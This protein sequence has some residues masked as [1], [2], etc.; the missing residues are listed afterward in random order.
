MKKKLLVISAHPDDEILGCG[1]S[2]A[3]FFR[4]GYEIRTLILSKGIDSRKNTKNKEIK[5]ID[6]IKAAVKANRIVGSKK[7]VFGD[8]PDNKFDTVPLLKIAQTIERHINSFKPQIIFTHHFNDLNIDHEIVNRASIIATRPIPKKNKFKILTYEV[9]SSTDWANNNKYHSFRANYFI[10]ISKKDLAKKLEALRCYKLEMR[11]WPH[12]RS[13]QAIKARSKLR[14]SS[15]G[16][17]NAEAFQLYRQ[18]D[19]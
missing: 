1:A 11:N 10:N 15:V 5:K 8:F 14:G 3:N 6:L 18:V 9:N 16:L 2:M 17:E 7:I 4:K 19:F 13:L 12:T